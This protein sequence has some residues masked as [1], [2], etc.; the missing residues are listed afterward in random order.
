MNSWHHA[1]ATGA[2]R[3]WNAGLRL[4]WLEMIG[5]ATAAEPAVEP[6]RIE[7]AATAGEKPYAVL[8]DA[9]AKPE[10]KAAA[11]ATLAKLRG[12][13]ADGEE[14]FDRTCFACH[15][16]DDFG[17]SLGPDLSDA[18][19][20]LTRREIAEAISD[21]AAKVDAKYYT[22]TVTTADGEILSGFIEKEDEKSITLRLGAELLQVIPKASV[23]KRETAMTSTMPADT[24]TTL[25]AE[26]F[27]DLIEFLA[28][29][30]PAEK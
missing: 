28:A 5:G 25:T 6:A 26:E 15:V 8:L 19:K 3:I 30:K 2:W 7:G 27:V 10:A 17:A 21:P 29:Q 13:A 20:K 16:I 24:L 1:T 9:K 12:D 18:G 14:V 11:L 4:S 23:K 22:E